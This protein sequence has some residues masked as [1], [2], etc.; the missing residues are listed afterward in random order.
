MDKNISVLN[1]V[2]CANFFQN[3]AACHRPLINGRK[4]GEATGLQ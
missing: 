2:N 3:K 4:S 1:T